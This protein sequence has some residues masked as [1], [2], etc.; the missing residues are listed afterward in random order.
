LSI[1]SRLTFQ[2]PSFL[3]RPEEKIKGLPRII[4]ESIGRDINDIYRQ[5][6]MGNVSHREGGRGGGKKREREEGKKRRIR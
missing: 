1:H 2:P 6:N 5:N 4:A 3:P